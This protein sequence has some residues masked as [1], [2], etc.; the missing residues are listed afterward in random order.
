MSRQHLFTLAILACTTLLANAQSTAFRVYNI[1]QEKCVQCHNPTSPS[2]GLDLRGNGSTDQERTL[3]VYNR[4]YQGMP[5]NGTAAQAKDAYIYPGR[6]DKSYL[7]RKIND[8]IESTLAL[9]PGEG[10]SM[11]PEGQP[12]LND[13]EKELIRQWILFGAPLQGEVVDE[14]LIAEYYGGNAMQSFP[15]GPP[16]SPAHDEGFQIKMGP[17]YL[18]PGDELEFF[19]KYELDL[20]ADQEVTR[21]DMQIGTFSHHFILY[22]FNPGGAQSIPPGLRLA[23]DHSN[24]SLVAAVQEPTD[25]QLPGGTAFFWDDQLVLDLNAHYINYSAT[26]VY[27]AEV[28][29]NVYT[30][31]IGTAAQEM[32]T[33]L[34]AN[35]NIYIPNDGDEVSYSQII[36][37]QFGEIFL[38]GLMGHTHQY[39]T[40]YKI[41]ERQLDG[42]ERLVYDGAC[43]QAEPGCVSPFFDY[44]HIPLRYFEPLRSLM[45]SPQQGLRHEASW[46]N[47]GPSPVSFGPT[48]D[49]EM[50]VMIMMYTTDTTGVTPTSTEAPNAQPSAVS[51]FPNPS[52][53]QVYVD[54][55]GAGERLTFQLFDLQGRPVFS[56][57]LDAVAGR[58][59]L[60]LP[61]LPPGVYPYKVQEAGGRWGAGKLVLRP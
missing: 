23:A 41:Y 2:G 30:Q 24:I 52:A 26:A 49:D 9:Q 43:P 25:L 50:M 21:L 32:Q 59:A 11:P 58:A 46:V 4:L 31:P 39:G 47:N 38:W 19:Q 10:Q 61:D 14:N 56:K 8:G 40:G 3:E 5:N 27:Q 20:P 55:K 7:F 33:D 44:Q 29:V 45:M 42:S 53:D 35:L 6:T 15:D 18:E 36:N 17:F 57:Q 60:R 37:P 34:I 13:E 12:A 48:S 28:Y 1:L 51:V 54:W 22:D 16:A